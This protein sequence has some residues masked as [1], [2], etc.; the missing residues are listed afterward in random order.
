MGQDMIPLLIGTLQEVHAME[1]EFAMIETGIYYRIR[2]TN[3]NGM[4]KIDW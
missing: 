4:Q 1:P 3:I 2:T